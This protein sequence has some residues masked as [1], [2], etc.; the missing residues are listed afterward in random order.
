MGF[1][2]P[3][4]DRFHIL[5]QLRTAISSSSRVLRDTRFSELCCETLLKYWVVVRLKGRVWVN[6]MTLGFNGHRKLTLFF[7]VSGPFPHFA[8]FRTV[9]SSSSRALEVTQCSE[10]HRGR[11]TPRLYVGTAD[12]P[13]ILAVRVRISGMTM[14]FGIACTGRT[15]LGGRGRR[16]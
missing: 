3:F 2:S 12:T 5:A 4:W 7:T 10:I 13:Q 11:D 15:R 14:G 16:E 1:G 9:I 8:E 6:C